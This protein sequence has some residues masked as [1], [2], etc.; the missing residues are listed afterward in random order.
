MAD[1]LGIIVLHPPVSFDVIERSSNVEREGGYT[2]RQ[3]T[4][5][6]STANPER[7]GAIILLRCM[8][9]YEVLEQTSRVRVREQFFRARFVQHNYYPVIR[10]GTDN[11]RHTARPTRT[12]SETLEARSPR[13]EAFDLGVVLGRENTLPSKPLRKITGNIQRH[14]QVL[15]D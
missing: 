6:W 1:T 2:S 13:H 10:R 5:I 7:F 15:E 14:R 8:G 9:P 3:I 4:I 12:R 11:N